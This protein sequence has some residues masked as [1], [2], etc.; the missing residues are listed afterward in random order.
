MPAGNSNMLADKIIQLA[1]DDS[2]RKKLEKG[3][4]KTSEQI[5]SEYQKNIFKITTKA[6]SED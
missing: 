6:Y 3:A 4:M 5:D 1:N 2:L